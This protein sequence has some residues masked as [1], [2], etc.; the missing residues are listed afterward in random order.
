MCGN[1]VIAFVEKS[2]WNFKRLFHRKLSQKNLEE[3]TIWKIKSR[4]E[5]DIKMDRNRVEHDKWI[6]FVNLWIG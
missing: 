6:G 1:I 4:W 3:E 2:E 5:Y